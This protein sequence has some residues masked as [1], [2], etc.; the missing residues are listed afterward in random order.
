MARWIHTTRPRFIFIQ[1]FFL[2]L[3]LEKIDG[4]TRE[5]THKSKCNTNENNISYI[6]RIEK[7]SQK[8]NGVQINASLSVQNAIACNIGVCGLILLYLILTIFFFAE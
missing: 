4:K 1:F 3:F 5:N 6:T 7:K 8:Q 2:I